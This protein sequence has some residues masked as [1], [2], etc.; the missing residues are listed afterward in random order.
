M[1]DKDVQGLKD[2][3]NSFRVR[4]ELQAPAENAKMVVVSILILSLFVFTV[5]DE[6]SIRPIIWYWAGFMGLL[7][8]GCAIQDLL[9]ARKIKS[10][11]KKK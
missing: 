3:F 11:E 6:E 8:V 5:V 10:L 9:I 1:K 4:R 7:L 2:S